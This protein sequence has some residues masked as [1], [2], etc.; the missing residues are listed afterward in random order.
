MWFGAISRTADRVVNIGISSLCKE[1]LMLGL[2]TED[3]VLAE[4]RGKHVS[5]T[6][7]H[8][9]GPNDQTYTT[10]AWEMRSMCIDFK[11]F[12][13]RTTGDNIYNDIEAFLNKFMGA[14]DFVQDTIGITDTNWKHGQTGQV[15]ERKWP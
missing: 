11:V 8:W 9:S 7:D 3:A 12:S 2:I 1:V 15:P 5:Y 4:L 10:D 13:G 14:S 6:S